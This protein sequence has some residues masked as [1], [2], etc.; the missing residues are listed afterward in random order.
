LVTRQ[1]KQH[2]YH[3]FPDCPVVTWFDRDAEP[4]LFKDVKR[5]VANR[6]STVTNKQASTIVARLPMR[7]SLPLMSVQ[8][9]GAGKMLFVADHSFF[10]NEMLVHEDNAQ[11]VNNVTRWLCDSDQRTRLVLINDG[12]VLPNWT[13]GESPPSIPLSSLLRAAKY[14]SLADLPLGDSLLPF[15]NESISRSQQENELN[16]AVRR[17]AFSLSGGRG[18]RL[19]VLI[20]TLLTM[21]SFVAWLIG[22]R[23]TPRRWL[24]FQDWHQPRRRMRSAPR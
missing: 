2:S 24:A 3:N 15:L 9:R 18:L 20:A 23:V 17:A 19:A 21:V 7:G 10:V 12:N 22:L 6:P 11:F 4:E 16:T 5:L 8:R 14:G 13:F 1:E